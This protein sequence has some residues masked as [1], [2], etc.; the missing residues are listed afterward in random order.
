M[1]L[2]SLFE[3]YCG[4]PPR[5]NS[6]FDSRTG[7]HYGRLTFT[8]LSSPIFNEFRELFYPNG[9]KAV[10]SN[11]GDILTARSLA[12]WAMDD[13]TRHHSGFR[14][15][16]QGFTVPDCELLCSVRQV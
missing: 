2:Y 9:T 13:G 3:A 12:Y 6:N 11:L 16:T 15:N 8:T 1:H 10:P 7:K 4:T 5:D 14:L